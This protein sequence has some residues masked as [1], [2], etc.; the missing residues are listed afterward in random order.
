MSGASR[1]SN[2]LATSSQPK[3]VRTAP[4]H[5]HD[6][7]PAT[8]AAPG[9]RLS[10]ALTNAPGRPHRCNWLNAAAQSPGRRMWDAPTARAVTATNHST[11]RSISEL[12][13]D[14]LPAGSIARSRFYI[15]DDDLAL[16]SSCGRKLA[17]GAYRH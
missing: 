6:A 2:P 3:A 4:G 8:I 12:D 16:V 14:G 7:C 13:E 10:A 1:Q 9:T 15:P 11:A 5:A 17:A